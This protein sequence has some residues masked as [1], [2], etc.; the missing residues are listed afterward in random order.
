MFNIIP[1]NQRDNQW[2]NVP[3]GTSTSTTIG[4]HGCTITC[5]TM[6]LNY[7]GYQETPITVNQKLKSNGG[8]ANTN[9][10]VWTAIPKIW[11]RMKFEWRGYGYDNNQVSSNLPCL[12]EV[13]F[14]GTERTD[15]RHWIL[16]K[17]DKKM[18][19]P[20]TGT[21]EPTSKYK[22]LTGYAVITGEMAQQPPTGGNNNMADMYK[23]IDLNN[24][25]SVKVA[26][27]LWADVVQNGKAIITKQELEILNGYKKRVIELE[28][29]ISKV[30]TDSQKALELKDEEYLKLQTAHNMLIEFAEP[31]AEQL[32]SY[33]IKYAGV[34]GQ[35]D[36]IKRVGYQSFAI[37]TTAWD[38]EETILSHLT[39]LT[40][41]GN[42]ENI[43]TSKL[44]SAIFARLLRSM[45]RN[46]K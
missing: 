30:K 15:D 12:V 18:N 33:K 11:T 28:A 29:E 9:L 44:I 36:T 10:I 4:S 17:G 46:A 16:F 32:E 25:E 41:G 7:F 35:L 38:K 22:I 5:L 14:D 34:L 1:L 19:D 23:G 24:K 27:D 37:P 39:A 2:K 13:D 6:L 26:V 43:S 45:D 42:I 3:L 40:S 21:E 31:L 8:Y 20:W